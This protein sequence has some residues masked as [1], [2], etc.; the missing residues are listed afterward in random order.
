LDALATPRTLARG[1]TSAPGWHIRGLRAMSDEAGVRLL[2]VLG[3]TLLAILALPIILVG[4]VA[5]M[6]DLR[7]HPFF[8][9]RRIGRRGRSFPVLKLRTLA[10]DAPRYADK[11]AIARLEFRPVG[12]LLRRLHLDELPQLFLV[13][14]GYM[15]LVG[16]RPEMVHLYAEMPERQAGTRVR[17]RPGCTG[18]WQ[19]SEGYSHLIGETPEYDIYYVEYRTFRLDLWILW[20]TALTMS[21]F[22]RPVV[23]ADIPRWTYSTAARRAFPPGTAPRVEFERRRRPRGAG[24]GPG[25]GEWTTAGRPVQRHAASSDDRVR[26][27]RTLHVPTDER[28]PA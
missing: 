16:P 11:Y 21:G 27:D 15:S 17:R 20:R 12:R 19:I 14:L 23:L 22:G 8:V 2:D 1:T 13:P 3:G 5:V 9:H 7:A 28:L 18:L 10:P 25:R 6:V 26:R 4:A 24:S